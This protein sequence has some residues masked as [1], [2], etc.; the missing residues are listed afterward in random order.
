MKSSGYIGC[1]GE[2]CTYLDHHELE[3]KFIFIGSVHI[4]LD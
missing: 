3:S 1:S 4:L 2:T